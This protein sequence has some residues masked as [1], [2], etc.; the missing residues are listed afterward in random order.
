MHNW[1]MVYMK[2]CDGGSFSGSNASATAM[3]DGTRLHFRGKHILEAGI[4]DLLRARGLARATDVVVSG[5][6]A[7]GLAA[8]LHCERFA[9]RVRAEG[10]AAAKVVCM[11]DSGL[12]RDYQGC[13]TPGLCDGPHYHDRLV[14]VF[15]SVKIFLFLILL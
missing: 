1:N 10:N 12:F 7:G 9:E 13:T 2:Y 14:W 6:S 4:S 11:P 8:F 15:E 3:P 5:C